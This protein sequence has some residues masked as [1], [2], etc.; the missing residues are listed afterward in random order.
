MINIQGKD[1]SYEHSEILDFAEGII[2]FP[3]MRRAVL[4]PFAEDTPFC[5]LASL[6]NEDVRFIVVNPNQIFNDY[7]PDSVLETDAKLDAL[8]IVKISS[9]WRKTTF[10]LR[11]PI[12]VNAK[13]RRAAQIIL[14]N[15]D[16]KHAEA[17]PNN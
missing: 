15:T 9:D 12:F 13:T 7:K 11:A 6:D 3:E 1:Y 16:Y 14:D 17:L 2:G 5:W 10:N 8:T 4:V